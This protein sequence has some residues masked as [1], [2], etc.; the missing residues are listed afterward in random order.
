[1]ILCQGQDHL[2]VSVSL[3]VSGRLVVGVKHRFKVFSVLVKHLGY[4]AVIMGHFIG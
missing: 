3:A 2:A 4:P 1:M